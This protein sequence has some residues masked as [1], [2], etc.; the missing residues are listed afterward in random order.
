MLLGAWEVV[1][2]LVR[3]WTPLQLLLW[4]GSAVSGGYDNDASGDYSS[5]LGGT[6]KVAQTIYSTSYAP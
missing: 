6:G 5:I 1:R 4:F 2:R 3:R